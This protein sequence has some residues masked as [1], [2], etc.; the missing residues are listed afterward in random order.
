M[1]QQHSLH[2]STQRGMGHRR[3]KAQGALGLA[4]P[5]R[6][7]PPAPPTSATLTLEKAQQLSAAEQAAYDKHQ[8]AYAASEADPAN[9]QKSAGRDAAFKAWQTARQACL[10]A[11]AQ[12]PDLFPQMR[13]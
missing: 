13:A 12:R 9:A 2:R 11:K 8:R 10:T 6:Q 5:A 3:Y 7:A 4:C 1:L